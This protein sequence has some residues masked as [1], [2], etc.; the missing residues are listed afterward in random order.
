MRIA[1]I[2][3]CFFI[4]GLSVQAQITNVTLTNG[5][6]S[7]TGE[8]Q[9]T[10]SYSLVAGTVLGGGVGTTMAVQVSSLGPS[11]ARSFVRFNLSSIPTNAIITSA[12][13]ILTPSGAENVSTT[14]NTTDLTLDLCNTSWTETT[15]THNTGISNNTLFTTV[16]TSSYN[17]S[18]GK[19]EFDVKDHL[20]ALVEGRAPNYG[21]RI[22]RTNESTVTGTTAYFTKDSPTST[23]WPTLQV[24]YYIPLSVTGATI[25]HESTSGASDGS[26]TATVANGSSTSR[27][28]QWYNSAGT[29]LSSGSLTLTGRSY[30]WYG[31]KITGTGDASDV[32]YFAFLIGLKCEAVSISFNPGVN[33]MD[34]AP[35]IDLILGS[36]TTVVNRTQVNDGGYNLTDAEQF[37]FGSWFKIRSLMKFK[38]W[39]PSD[40]NVQQAKL[41]LTGSNHYP[42]NRSN[43]SELARVTSYW[44]E[45]GVAELNKPTQTT[46]VIDIPGTLPL[47]STGNQNATIDIASFFNT[48]KSNNTQNY[49]LYFQLKTYD[50]AP[51]NTTSQTRMQ[52]MSSENTSPPTIDFK[53]DLYSNPVCTPY[54][55]L[56]YELDGS[57]YTM[58]NGII[59]FIFDQEYDKSNLQFK[60]FNSMDSQVK[61][62]TDFSPIVVTHGENYIDLDVSN[63]TTCIGN[64]FFYLEVTNDKKEKLYLRFYND[65]NNCTIPGET[66]G[67]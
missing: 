7:P 67:Q 4:S 40:I 11:Y 35:L 49:G 39:I 29:L 6:G 37:Q 3:S 53:V 46:G 14:A 5:T 10:S 23:N 62:N 34:D 24:S 17:S 26:I 8:D 60:I 25:N 51:T 20:Q 56:E 43:I 36:G 52:Y 31:L 28:Y 64:G 44:R 33:Y 54:A 66:E 30:G 48:W 2:I 16:G 21:W 63:N 32:S 41:N 19:R 18:T 12:K 13:L 58:K 22:K 27:T 47:G 42:L 59:K 65:Y 9:S 1:F 57:Y 38:L 15:L 45:Y 61:S 50:S 55:T